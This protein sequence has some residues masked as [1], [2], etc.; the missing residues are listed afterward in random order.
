MGI[1]VTVNDLE[2]RAYEPQEGESKP[3]PGSLALVQRFINTLQLED[4]QDRL[5]TESLAAQWLAEC[6]GLP[7]PVSSSDIGRLVATREALRDLLEAHTGENVDPAVNVRLQKLLGNAPLHMTLT[8]SGATLGCDCGGVDQ[9]LGMVSSAII[10]STLL[11]TWTRLKIC[12]SSTCRWAYYDHSKN[13]SGAWCSMRSCG[14]REKA[15]AYR[16]RRRAGSA[17]THSA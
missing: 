7:E 4:G 6:A 12:R 17:H 10:Q 1:L 9:F 2:L 16:A 8:A 15:R 13:G 11:G 3:A 5:R 14:S